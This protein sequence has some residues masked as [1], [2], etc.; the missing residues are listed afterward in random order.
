[1]IVRLSSRGNSGLAKRLTN[2]A[3]MLIAAVLVVA[4]A[5]SVQFASA[6]TIV[7]DDFTQPDPYSLFM[8]GSGMNPSK[9]LVESSTGAIGGQRNALFNV[10]GQGQPNSAV[11]LLGF[12]PNSAHPFPGPGMQ[13]ATNGFSPTVSTLT[14]GATNNLG[15][16]L[17]GD[18]SN[19]SFMLD[20]YSSDAQP[21]TGLDL[22]ITITSPG[23]KSS[24][25]TG[26][27]PNSLSEFQYLVPF[28]ELVGDASLSN[29]ST[30]QYVLN[31]ANHTPNIDYE[32][33]ALAVVPE[34][35]SATLM[36]IAAVALGCT[37]MTRCRSGIEQ[38]C[39]SGKCQSLVAVI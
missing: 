6:S 21:T 2:A 25:A 11:G 14:Y 35:T 1:M 4:F 22:S 9:Q 17:T 10:M 31:G 37:V 28:S 8:L 24:T 19:N 39:C 26:I 18:G 12:D 30:I 34:P 15:V 5:S 33:H 27:M 29:V 3:I 38:R 16:D 13:L 20:F 32:I 36:A 7:I 23:G